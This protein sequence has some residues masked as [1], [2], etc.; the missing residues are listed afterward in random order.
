MKGEGK[1]TPLTLSLEQS[2]TL[3]FLCTDNF[4]FL[5]LIKFSHAKKNGTSER[6]PFAW[7]LP[8]GQTVLV[9][10]FSLFT[11]FSSQPKKSDSCHECFLNHYRLGSERGVKGCLVRKHFLL[12]SIVMPVQCLICTR[13]GTKLE[14]ISVRSLLKLKG[15]ITYSKT[16]TKLCT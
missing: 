1:K 4:G 10:V 16:Y 15:A 11:A 14:V 7:F 2:A 3:R 6:N 9:K 8:Q 12:P 5:Y 13:S